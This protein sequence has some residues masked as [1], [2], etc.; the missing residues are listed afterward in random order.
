MSGTVSVGFKKRKMFEV[1]ERLVSQE[2]IFLG[3]SKT[4]NVPFKPFFFLILFYLFIFGCVGSI[5]AARGP[6]LVAASGGHSSLWCAGFSLWWLLLLRNMGFRCT[7]FSSCDTQAQ[8][9]WLAV[10][11]AQAQQLWRPGLVASQH[12]GSSRTRDQ[13]CV[14]CTGRQILI[15]CATREALNHFKVNK[16]VTLSTFPVLCNHHHCQFPEFFHHFKQKL[17]TH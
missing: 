15:H 16:S 6:S 17:C 1:V 10:S 14:P 8:Q 4:Q 3:L 5:V 7:D 9:L 12:V 2:W 13:T 11:R